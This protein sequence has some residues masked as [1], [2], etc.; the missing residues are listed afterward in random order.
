MEEGLKGW[1]TETGMSR[2][3]IANLV[4]DYGGPYQNSGFEE[5]E[6]ETLKDP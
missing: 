4:R 2:Q 1:K 6:E 5:D 3:D